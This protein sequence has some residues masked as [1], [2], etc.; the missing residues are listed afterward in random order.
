MLNS[1]I[2]KAVL[3]HLTDGNMGSTYLGLL[4]AGLLSANV[5]WGSLA[6]RDQVKAAQSWGL[7]IG[8]AI[9]ITW[10]YF[11]GKRTKEQV[12]LEVQDTKDDR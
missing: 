1:L 5:D 6:S 12:Q 2:I 8:V 11:T 10:G 9:V 7:V 4:A 3:R